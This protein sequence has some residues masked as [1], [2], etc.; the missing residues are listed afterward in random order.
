ML[1]EDGFLEKLVAEGGTLDQLVALG[2]TLEQMQPRLVQLAELI[3]SLAT[4]ADGLDQ[5]AGAGRARST[6]YAYRRLLT[7]GMG[8]NCWLS[9]STTPE[10]SFSAW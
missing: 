2:D 1:L 3:P 5:V 8:P 4:A 9:H 7:R 10:Q 6:R